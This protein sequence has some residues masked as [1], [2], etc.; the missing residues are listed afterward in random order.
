MTN[1]REESY[2]VRSALQNY[3]TTSWPIIQEMGI[4]AARWS[5]S[6]VTIKMASL[7]KAAHDSGL[8]YTLGPL[9]HQG[10]ITKLNKVILLNYLLL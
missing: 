5:V 3:T 7:D 2:I 8:M 10:A 1:V 6:S 9:F 4:F